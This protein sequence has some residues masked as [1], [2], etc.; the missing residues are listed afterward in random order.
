LA[1]S[2]FGELI[3]STNRGSRS[4]A[5]SGQ[6]DNGDGADKS[7]HNMKFADFYDRVIN[8]PNRT[9]LLAAF[10]VTIGLLAIAAF[11]LSAGKLR[12]F[13]RA[14][15]IVAVVSIMALLWITREQT[16]TVRKGPYI[17]ITTYCHPE[18]LRMG[19]LAALVALPAVASVVMST[20]FV[21]TSRQLR[22]RV[23]S[24][25]RAGRRHQAQKKYTAALHEY[26]Q[27]IK[28]SPNLAEAYFRRGALYQTMGEKALALADFERAIE[29][30]PRFAPAYT[31]R[32]KICLERGEFDSAL[33]DFGMLMTLR[34]NDPD[35]HLNRGICFLKKGLVRE[36]AADFQ[37][38]LK[39]TNH[40]DYAEPAKQYLRECESSAARSLP[41]AGSNGSATSPASSE[42][43]SP[44][45]MI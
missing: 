38:V 11:M 34:A 8:L 28:T 35:T 7:F 33:A 10:G 20:V 22:E 44:E 15:G 27:A 21:S 23:P 45:F 17:T 36:A 19:F 2:G 24:R 26:N 31:Q 18:R 25:L 42:P 14:L 41:A 1:R 16:V 29:R 5:C 32:G 6:D 43:I 37:R 30:D 3:A 40:S 13:S 9:A 4:E 12:R 39:L